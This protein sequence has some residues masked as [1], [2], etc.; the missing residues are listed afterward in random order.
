MAAALTAMAGAVT[1]A[2]GYAAL[3]PRASNVAA[4]GGSWYVSDLWAGGV[5]TTGAVLT[6]LF[7]AAP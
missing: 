2:L 5:L 7:C 6:G 4:A 1:G 3:L